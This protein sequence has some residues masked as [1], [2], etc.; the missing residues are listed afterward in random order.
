MFCG[1][2]MFVRTGNKQ[3][4]SVRK[5]FTK[6]LC[7]PIDKRRKQI[8]IPIAIAETAVRQKH[9]LPLVNAAVSRPFAAL[10]HTSAGRVIPMFRVGVRVQ[11]QLL[12]RY[13]T[14]L[15]A[16]SQSLV[17]AANSHG[18][19]SMKRVSATLYAGFATVRF[20]EVATLA[21]QTAARINRIGHKANALL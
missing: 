2:P 4:F 13:F 12:A 14:A 8:K 6:H 18:T 10:L 15:S 9:I 1:L 7:K 19:L 3:H 5:R 20:N 17:L 16:M 11:P 21:P